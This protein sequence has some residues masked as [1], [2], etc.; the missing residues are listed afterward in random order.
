[1]HQQGPAPQQLERDG[2]GKVVAAVGAAMPA[3]AF[4]SL[5]CSRDFLASDKAKA[6]TR[7]Y[8]RSRAWARSAPPAQVAKA[9]QGLFPNISLDA[10]TDAIDAYQR[11]GCWDGDIAIPEPLY[12][13][14]LEVFLSGGAITKRHRYELVTAP[15]PA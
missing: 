12:E 7:A 10:L 13:Q 5:C 14:A 11:L 9:E 4:S 2:G 15:P 1:V 6:F 8:R 3:V